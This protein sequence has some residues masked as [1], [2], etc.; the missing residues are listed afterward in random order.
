MSCTSILPYVSIVSAMRRSRAA[1]PRSLGVRL[2]EVVNYPTVGCVGRRVNHTGF[3]SDNLE[4][5]TKMRPQ[6]TGN[7]EPIA[8]GLKVSAGRD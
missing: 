6:S 7:V 2:G 5:G 3:L 4:S 1:V 8:T